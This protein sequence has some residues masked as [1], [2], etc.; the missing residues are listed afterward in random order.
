MSFK[1]A[2]EITSQGLMAANVEIHPDGGWSLC[3]G[4]NLRILGKED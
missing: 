3:E 4:G 1:T 2:R